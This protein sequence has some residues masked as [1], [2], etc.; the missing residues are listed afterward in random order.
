MRRFALIILALSLCG[1]AAATDFQ[2]ASAI[3]QNTLQLRT[4]VAALRSALTQT[5]VN[6]QTTLTIYTPALLERA[7]AARSQAT[8]YRLKIESQLEVAA[9]KQL[10]AEVDYHLQ[11]LDAAI[12]Q[13]VTMGLQVSAAA[14]KLEYI[15][16]AIEEV[17]P[18]LQ[19]LVAGAC[20]LPHASTTIAKGSCAIAACEK[21]WVNA[22][23]NAANGCEAP[24]R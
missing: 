22:D 11:N 12:Q 5:G 2:Q 16:H 8:A 6:A 15:A 23:G 13:V 3:Q 7:S 17:L 19:A 1:T 14:Q 20:T 10:A 18:K 9:N 24:I 21:N 4:D